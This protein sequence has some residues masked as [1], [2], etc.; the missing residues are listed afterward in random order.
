MLNPADTFS[1]ARAIFSSI[2]LLGNPAHPAGNTVTM[3]TIGVDTNYRNLAITYYNRRLNADFDF[4]SSI[5]PL[6][7]K[8]ILASNAVRNISYDNTE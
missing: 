4:S 5:I 1:H 8:L 6:A 2:L 7:E 3:A